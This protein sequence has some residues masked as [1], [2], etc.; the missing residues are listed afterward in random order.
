M[1]S[2]EVN[3]DVENAYYGQ[4]TSSEENGYIQVVLAVDEELYWNF[5]TDLLCDMTEKSG[6]DYSYYVDANDL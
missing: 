1:L 5:V 3:T 2:L 4:V 6:Q